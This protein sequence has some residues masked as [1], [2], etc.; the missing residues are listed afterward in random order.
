MTG[1]NVFDGSLSA[2]A[3]FGRLVTYGTAA[4]QETGPVAPGALLQ[5]SRAVVGFWLAR[6]MARPHMLDDAM[7]EL[8]QSVAVGALRPVIGGRYPLTA[9]REAHRGPA[10]PPH[11]RQAR[12]RPLPLNGVDPCR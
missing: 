1:G 6:C 10:R 7:T 2:L 11:H 8:L 3:P 4:R 9:V 5:R 12:P